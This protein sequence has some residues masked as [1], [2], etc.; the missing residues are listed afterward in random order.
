MAE[1]AL[2]PW[3][4]AHAD[5]A[6][7]FAQ[8]FRQASQINATLAAEAARMQQQAVQSQMEMQARQQE[9]DKQRALEQQKIAQ[10]KARIDAE[11]GLRSQAI[12]QAQ[13][14]VDLATKAAAQK[15]AA[16]QAFQAEVGDASDP[17]S[18][19]RAL[20]K[21]GPL[22]GTPG[23]GTATA[24]AIRASSQKEF[25]AGPVQGQPVLDPSGQAVP[26]ALAVPSPTGRGMQVH[27]SKEQPELSA[28]ERQQ[29]LRELDSEEKDI[30]SSYPQGIKNAK[31]KNKEVAA[32]LELDRKRLQEIQSQKQELLPRIRPPAKGGT[33]SGPTEKVWRDSSGRRWRY[34]GDA[35]DPKTD[36]NPEHWQEI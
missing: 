25:Q 28:A 12:Q 20:M 35:K 8:S 3:L 2:P 10:D 18:V 14:K 27:W 5:P 26:G 33:P 7:E 30:K 19:T 21:Y 22:M 15:Y 11:L 4:A 1:Y 34:T 36:K 32:Q 24:A 17:Q 9:N 31:P 23:A 6:A 13:Q 16:T 29:T